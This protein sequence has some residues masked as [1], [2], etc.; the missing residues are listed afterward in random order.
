LH[1]ELNLILLVP[2]IT[3]PF[4]DDLQRSGLTA[5]EEELRIHRIEGHV[6]TT[7]VIETDLIAGSDQPERLRELLL[8]A[9]P[10]P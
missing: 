4:R 2:A 10:E 6:F 9:K 1:T 5:H 8:P 7:W 3:Q